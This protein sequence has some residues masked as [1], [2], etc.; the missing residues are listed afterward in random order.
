[1]YDAFDQVAV[2][3]FRVSREVEKETGKS[4]SFFDF[5]RGNY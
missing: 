1:M 3:Y 5:I 2:S 4:L